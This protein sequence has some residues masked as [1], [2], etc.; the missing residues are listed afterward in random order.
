MQ[1]LISLAALYPAWCQAALLLPQGSL[2][3]VLRFCTVAQTV[4][5]LAAG[6]VIEVAFSCY[7]GAVVDNKYK[8]NIR[9]CFSNV[10]WM[11]RYKP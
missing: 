9:P 10:F 8:Y 7:T 5:D 11:R 3:S 2:T 4:E 1:A 6:S